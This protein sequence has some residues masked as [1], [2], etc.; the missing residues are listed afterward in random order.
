MGENAS[1]PV[2]IPDT[3]SFDLVAANGAAYRIFL[4]VPSGEAPPQGFPVAYMLDAN[5]GFASFVETMR[6]GAVRPQGT[7]IGPTVIVG[8]G[9]PEGDDMRARRSCDYTAGPS[10]E[11]WGGSGRPEHER[12]SG[13]RDA[14]VAFIEAV[15]KPRISALTRIDPARQMLFGHSL[16]GWFVL[17][18]LARNSTAFSAYVAAS[19]SVWW[20][21]ARLLE[22]LPQAKGTRLRLAVMV[23][24]WEQALAPWQ[25]SRPEASEMAARRAKR[26]MVDRARAYAAEAERLLSP[27]AYIDFSVMPDEDHASILAVAM[28]RALRLLHAS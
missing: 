23:G 18:V 20:D 14:F 25:A 5:A 13:G 6:R 1:H 27:Q 9:Y 7:G 15:V 26:G 3:A 24:E 8:I 16:A 2:I 17:D 22:G 11:A 10:P 19:P 21:E 28:V 12:P 4:A